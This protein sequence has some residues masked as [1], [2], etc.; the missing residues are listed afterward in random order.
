M[1]KRVK[2]TS[3]EVLYSILTACS[4]ATNKTKIMYSAGINL[5]E[6][7]RYLK[8]LERGGYIVKIKQGSRDLY[9]LTEKGKD[10][11]TRLERY[12]RVL[13]EYE[14]AKQQVNDLISLI[15]NKN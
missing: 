9:S 14:D 12:V 1:D 6:L 11:V 13:K 2:R 10:A 5:V 3:L 7:T 4:D 15:K 8:L